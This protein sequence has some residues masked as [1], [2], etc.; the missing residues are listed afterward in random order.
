MTLSQEQQMD[1]VVI[2]ASGPPAQSLAIRSEAVPHPGPGE[3]LV[4]VHAAAVNPFDAVNALGLLGTPLPIIP[5]IDFAGI[6]VSDGELTGQEVWGSVTDPSL[7]RPGTH[8]RFVSLPEAWL[9]RKPERLTMTEAAAVGRSH[10]AAWE[11][12]IERGQL[13]AAETLLIT[14]GAGMVG[15]AATQIARWRGAVPIVAD[16][17]NP[18]DIEH[19]I[20]TSSTDLREAVLDL[21]AGRGADMVLDAVGGALFEP[22]LRSVRFGG[23]MTGLISHEPRVEFDLAEFYAREVQLSSLASLFTDGAHIASVFDQL[24][25]LYDRGL[26]TPPAT[27]TWPL[28]KSAEAYQTVLDGSGGIKQVVLPNGAGAQEG[29]R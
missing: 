4:E 1:A 16:L 27:K 3:V 12:L 24:A 8:A 17:R 10:L 28:E 11:V 18:G 15:Q 13:K 20:D 21:T 6:V 7:K 25:A 22:A 29:S 5:G 2:K 19:F 23:R 14:G 26:L 9:S